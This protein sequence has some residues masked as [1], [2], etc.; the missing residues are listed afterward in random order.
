MTFSTLFVVHE[1]K[2]LAIQIAKC[3]TSFYLGTEIS[4]N[5]KRVFSILYVLQRQFRKK[6]SDGSHAFR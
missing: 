3:Q 4:L 1:N 6:L 5:E 2:K